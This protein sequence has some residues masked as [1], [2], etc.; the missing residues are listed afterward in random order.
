MRFL[1]QPSADVPMEF[2]A[3]TRNG[4]KA[5]ESV[6]ELDATAT[7]FNLACLLIGLDPEAATP[8]LGGFDPTPVDG[9]PVALRIEWDVPGSSDSLPAASFL[10]LEDGK[11]AT[12]DWVY[13]GSYF[14]AD[15][16]F[17]AAWSQILIGFSHNPESIIQHRSGLGLKRYGAIRQSPD[18]LSLPP[19]LTLRV[20]A[21]AE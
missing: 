7:E 6:M 20:S 12:G 1:V 11:T 15:G 19:A 9:D 14:G 8:P 17:A 5:Y 18:F 10:L 21:I 16:S 3:V 4:S 2:L 13:V